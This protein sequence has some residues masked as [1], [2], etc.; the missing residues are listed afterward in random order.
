M[1]EELMK[2]LCIQG[3]P[4]R[5]GNTAKILGWVE[6]EIRSHGHDVEHI[7]IEDLSLEG[8]CGCYFCQ[9]NPDELEC[10]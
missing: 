7:H 5:K 10:S 1:P 2:V 8:C 4:R 6:E 9:I 3:S